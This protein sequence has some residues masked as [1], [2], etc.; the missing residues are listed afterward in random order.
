[1]A[2]SIFAPHPQNFAKI[3]NFCRC[4]NDVTIIFWYLYF[5]KIQ[6]INV[7]VLRPYLDVVLDYIQAKE[8]QNCTVSKRCPKLVQ[9]SVTDLSL[10]SS[11]SKTPS[12]LE[13]QLKN[14]LKVQL[15]LQIVGISMKKLFFKMYVSAKILLQSAM[16]LT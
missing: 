7:G 6:K 5:C 15:W 9:N 12:N 3:F 8:Y 10:R 1:M 13:M 14:M 16:Q 4:T 11:K 2:G